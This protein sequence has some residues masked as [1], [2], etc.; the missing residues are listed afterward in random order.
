MITSL[1]GSFIYNLSSVSDSDFEILDK[2]LQI[3]DFKSEFPKLFENTSITKEN[4]LD[5]VKHQQ[6]DDELQEI[7]D[8]IL[9]LL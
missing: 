7:V 2:G 1:F 8:K 5:R 3:S 4:L 6:K 9:K